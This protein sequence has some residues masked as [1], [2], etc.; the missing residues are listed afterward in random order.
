MKGLAFFINKGCSINIE[1]SSNGIY[2]L[3]I[4]VERNNHNRVARGIGIIKENDQFYVSCYVDWGGD[5]YGAEYLCEDELMA[6]TDF[7]A[8][9]KANKEM[10][11][12]TFAHLSEGEKIDICVSRTKIEITNYQ[13]E[14]PYICS[15]TSNLE[16]HRE[17]SLPE[18][19]TNMLP[20]LANL[21]WN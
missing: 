21:F 6:V 10:I 16:M 12:T 9:Y 20:I 19:L 7:I 1:C 4:A 18:I 3:N 14:V 17:G 13:T 15:I 11:E 2:S 5:G 8:A